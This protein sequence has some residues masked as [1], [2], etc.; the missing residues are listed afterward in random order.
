MMTSDNKFIYRTHLEQYVGTEQEIIIPEG[1]AVINYRA[2]ENKKSNITAVTLPTTIEEIDN[3]TFMGCTS[4]KTVIFP[5]KVKRLLLGCDAFGDCTALQSIRL[6]DGA[7]AVWDAFTGC[8]ALS[9]IILP[10]SIR[11]IGDYA[12]QG[13][14]SLKKVKLPANLKYIS[15]NSFQGCAALTEIDIP[16]GIDDIWEHAFQDC[17]SLS[18]VQIPNGVIHVGEEAFAGCKNLSVIY[19]PDSVT[20]IGEKAFAGCA[21]GFVLQSSNPKW[22]EYARKERLKFEMIDDPYVK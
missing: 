17:E 5:D 16:D 20:Y 2:F 10:D 3:G 13:C 18:N 9:D 19:I 21:K 15:R 6:P 12:F 14:V 8:T 11:L 22:K 7:D 4:L 1:V